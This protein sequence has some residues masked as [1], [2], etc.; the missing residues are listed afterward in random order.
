MTTLVER[1]AEKTKADLANRRRGIAA[2]VA[3]HIPYHSE[4]P[5]DYILEA[6]A[7]SSLG[8]LVSHPHAFDVKP[9]SAWLRSAATF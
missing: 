5:A 9:I 4:E 8:R 2:L 3:G 1:G 6:R 7:R